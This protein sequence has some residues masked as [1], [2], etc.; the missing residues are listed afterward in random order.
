MRAETWKRAFLYAG[1]VFASAL[2]AIAIAELYFSSR[3]QS[4]LT[5]QFDNRLYPYV[6]FRP[7]ENSTY[8]TP[9][10]LVLSHYTSKV[11]H[12]T[13]VDGFR[14]SSPDYS[15]PKAKPPRQLRIAVLGASAIQLGSTFETTLP[16]SLKSFLRRQYPGRDIEV[17]NAGITACVSRQSIAHLVFTVA[18][19][20][21]D[22][23]I[24]YDGVNDIGLPVTYESRPNFPYNFQTMEEAWKLYRQSY[25]EPLFRLILNRS[26][27]YRAVRSRFRDPSKRENTVANPFIG[28]NAIPA[29]RV[30]QDKALVRDHIRQ[31]LSN[32]EKLIELSAA[33]KYKPVCVL[34]PTGG[35]DR[36]YGLSLTMRDFHLDKRTASNWL[37]A[38]SAFYEEADRQIEALRAVYP[39]V[40]F[41]NLR[42]SLK[43]AQK[44]F[45]DL[46]HVYDETNM[47]LAERLYRDTRHIIDDL[48]S[49]R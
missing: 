8:I 12:Y 35:L 13:N 49:R 42:D 41:I 48:L 14:V 3:A 32:W 34:Q 15:L 38:F 11:Y 10:T 17:I 19:Y 5:I 6:M 1:I 2:I 21:P 46:V 18:D 24:L 28:A 4:R 25:Q 27:V 31:Y 36:D 37:E 43:P 30:I 16:G 45:W 47:L 40:P 26:Y 7:Q 29:E 39:G 20:H 9:G 22:I 23:V 44:H 33:Y